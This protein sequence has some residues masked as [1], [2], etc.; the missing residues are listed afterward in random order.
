MA[1]A[2][3]AEEVLWR[4]HVG[5]DVLVQLRER[6]PGFDT[7][8]YLLVLYALTHAMRGLPER[9][10]ISGRELSEA[11]REVALERFGLLTRTVLAHW[12]IR[13]TED[14]GQVVFALVESGVLVKQDGDR[15]EDF[16]GVYDFEE[17]FEAGYPWGSRV[18]FGAVVEMTC[19][20]AGHR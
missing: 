7:R 9:R 12:G 11:V 3:F 17:A 5:E 10:H 13:S 8:A 15:L 1:Q 14:L 18:N 16:R 20:V 4:F 19:P 6:N 2:P